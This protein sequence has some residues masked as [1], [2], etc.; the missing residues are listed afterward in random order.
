MAGILPMIVYPSS[1]VE[2]D[3]GNQK[4]LTFQ[5][6]PKNL[7]EYVPEVTRHDHVSTAGVSQTLLERIDY[8]LTFQVP[9]IDDDD[10]F[11]GDG[12]NDL[13]RWWQFLQFA[14]TGQPFDFYIDAD[15]QNN[16]KTYQLW[17]PTQPIPKHVSPYRHSLDTLTF[18]EVVTG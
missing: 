2:S 12:L 1:L 6:P 16:F 11:D 15:D 13:G 14:M 7:D 5:H 3:A 9:W 10:N 17:A 18:R 8:Y 4:R